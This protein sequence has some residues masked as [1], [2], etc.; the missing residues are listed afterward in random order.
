MVFL[1]GQRLRF[2]EQ[3]DTGLHLMAFAVIWP[4]SLGARLFRVWGW[5]SSEVLTAVEQLQPPCW[6]SFMA[7][8]L[9]EAVSALLWLC[10]G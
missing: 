3:Q 5:K 6:S 7:A 4:I 10:Q 2:T 1:N 8:F 9:I